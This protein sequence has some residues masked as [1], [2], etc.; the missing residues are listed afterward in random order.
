MAAWAWLRQLWRVRVFVQTYGL[1]ST[2]LL[3]RFLVETS[4]SPINCLR[5]TSS[6][7]IAEPVMSRENRKQMVEPVGIC[8]LTSKKHRSSLH[9]ET[10]VV[11]PVGVSG[12]QA[13]RLRMTDRTLPSRD[14]LPAQKLLLGRRLEHLK[15]PAVTINRQHNPL[16]QDSPTLAVVDSDGVERRLAG[17]RARIRTILKRTEVFAYTDGQKSSSMSASR[18]EV[19]WPRRVLSEKSHRSLALAQP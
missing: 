11:I 15:C 2:P 3:V 1:L 10:T 14:I 17:S 18:V 12:S 7:P 9:V 16:R 5:F 4:R 13:F 19:V 6:V 8:T